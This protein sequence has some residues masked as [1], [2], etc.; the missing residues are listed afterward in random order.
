[1]TAPDKFLL[2]FASELDV[3]AAE[4]ARWPHLETGGDLFGYWTHSGSPIVHY[5][6]GPGPASAHQVAAFYQDE[7][8]LLSEGAALNDAYGLQHIGEWHS[9][10][11]LGLDHPSG[12][13]VDTVRRAL[14]R[15]GF[16]RFTLVIGNLTASGWAR[17]TIDAVH[18]NSFLFERD[19]RGVY[20]TCSWV[21]LPGVS[22]IRQLRDATGADRPRP[23]PIDL[24]P[25]RL[26]LEDLRRG[27]RPTRVEVEQ[28]VG[29]RW[30]TTAE[31]R[32]RLLAEKEG[33]ERQAPGVALS[34]TAE[35][36]IRF[37]VAVP[38]GA[39]HYLLPDAF[40]DEG[41]QVY[42]EQEAASGDLDLAALGVQ[43]WAAGATLE[44]LHTEL[45]RA[46][47]Y[48]AEQGEG[49]E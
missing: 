10:H 40:P 41:P 25:E 19:G 6:I 37:R 21:V 18:L 31:G 12:G 2:I 8:Y 28:V 13:D 14:D 4:A 22:P 47:S 35:N 1:M 46:L 9:H 33:L 34:L 48:R 23:P 39:L 26:T 44:D 7:D 11:Q 5:A 24:R 3:I 30:Y 29:N 38:G 20:N 42:R 27:S 49:G 17:R 45:L 36:R 32:R 43:P 16:P 15:Y